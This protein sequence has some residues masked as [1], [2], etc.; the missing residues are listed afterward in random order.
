MWQSLCLENSKILTFN[1]FNNKRGRAG[2]VK[3]HVGYVPQISS[4]LDSIHAEGVIVE[5]ETKL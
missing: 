4:L 2:E 5:T 1:L 3:V